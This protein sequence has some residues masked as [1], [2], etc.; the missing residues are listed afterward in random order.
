MRLVPASC[1]QLVDWAVKKGLWE[2]LFTP[3]MVQLTSSESSYAKSEECR[4]R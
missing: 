4:V 3:V 2:A 1:Y